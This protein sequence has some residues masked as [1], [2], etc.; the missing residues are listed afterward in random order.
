MNVLGTKI[1]ALTMLQDQG[2]GNHKAGGRNVLGTVCAWRVCSNAHPS[3]PEPA[4]KFGL[5]SLSPVLH[6]GCLRPWGYCL[7]APPERSGLAALLLLT[8]WLCHLAYAE[9]SVR[10]LNFLKWELSAWRSQTI[11]LNLPRASCSPWM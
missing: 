3:G 7:P 2:V 4:E 10:F 9:H 11:E 8:L 5:I 1:T 6:L